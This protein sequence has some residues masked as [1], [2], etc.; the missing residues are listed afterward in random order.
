MLASLH[1]PTVTDEDFPSRTPDVI[2]RATELILACCWCSRGQTR[3]L[4]GGLTV[5]PLSL[6]V[7]QVLGSFCSG[8]EHSVSV[9]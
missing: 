3:G 4:S 2:L 8:S 7:E 9:E 1:H 5:F 6:A